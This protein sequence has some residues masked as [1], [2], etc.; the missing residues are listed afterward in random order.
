MLTAIVIAFSLKNDPTWYHACSTDIYQAI[1]YFTMLGAKVHLFTNLHKFERIR[2][3]SNL[4]TKSLVDQSIYNFTFPESTYHVDSFLLLFE[5]LSKLEIN[6]KCMIYYTGHGT[7]ETIKFPA[8]DEISLV[9]FRKL[10]FIPFKKTSDI[11]IIT[12]CCNPNGLYLPMILKGK[13]FRLQNIDRIIPEKHNVFLIA[14]ARR[15]S[16]SLSSSDGSIFSRYFFSAVR[17]FVRGDPVCEVSLHGLKQYVDR[18]IEEIGREFLFLNE[19]SIETSQTLTYYASYMIPS[20]FP[21]FM[22]GIPDISFDPHRQIFI[23][24]SSEKLEYHFDEKERKILPKYT[25]NTSIEIS[26]LAKFLLKS[27]MKE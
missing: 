9:D 21:L 19:S 20:I 15:D 1:S 13:R 11:V 22:L 14:S 25:E 6:G 2:D 8:G 4:V 3:V 27:R 17:S 12:D 10:L 16:V 24:N 5:E 18:S 7:L 26:P 23:W